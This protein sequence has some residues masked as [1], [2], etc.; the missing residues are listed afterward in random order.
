MMMSCFILAGGSTSVCGDLAEYYGS[1]SLCRP[2]QGKKSCFCLCALEQ[3]IKLSA[4]ET[5]PY[6]VTSIPPCVLQS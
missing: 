1:S 5:F 3:G 6:W 2:K 4:D